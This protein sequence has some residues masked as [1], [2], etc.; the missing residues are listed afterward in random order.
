MDDRQT[1]TSRSRHA[2]RLREFP[3]FVFAERDVF[4][5]RGNWRDFFRQRMGAGFD[6][7]IIFEIGCFD[8]GYLGTIAAKYTTT[9]FI[10]L[11]WKCKPLVDGAERIVTQGIR[12]VALLRG[13]GQDVAKIFGD[14]EA[15]E[16]WLFHPDPCD[17]PAELRN[18]LFAEPFLLDA[19]RVLR[20]SNSP[21]CLKTDHPEYYRSAV[22]L[23][24]S[25]HRDLLQSPFTIS[26][27]SADYWNDPIAVAATASR[28][29][30][31]ETTLF[32]RRFIKKRQP[33]YY[34]EVRKK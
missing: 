30:S 3:E 22:A 4:R 21:L 23:L 12:N 1:I 17:K 19:H 33:I 7:R 14:G 18:R 26:I 13:R 28:C 11:D 34:L 2:A 10:G 31:N 24:E 5:H 9:G 6:E 8:A 20:D 32:E 27:N 16:I 15:D 29:F 25:E